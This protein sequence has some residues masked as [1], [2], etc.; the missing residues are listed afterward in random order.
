MCKNLQ[1]LCSVCTETTIHDLQQLINLRNI[2]L[3]DEKVVSEKSFLY[4]YKYNDG[5]IQRFL[6]ALFQNKMLN[7]LDIRLSKNF[8]EGIKTE[9]IT[10]PAS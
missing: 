9:T 7:Y 5:T 6:E 2:Y 3:Q 8:F 1:Y 10:I 4:K